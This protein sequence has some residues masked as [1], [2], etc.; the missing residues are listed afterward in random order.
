MK[1]PRLIIEDGGPKAPGYIVTF[2]DM[3]TLLLTF[4]VM[5]QTLASTQDAEIFNKGRDAFIK[6][7]RYIGLGVLFDRGNV[8]ALDHHKTKYYINNPEELT[9]KRTIDA[10][11]EEIRR[12]LERLRQSTTIVPSTIVGK[13]ANFSVANVHFSPGRD[14]LDGPAK[15]FLTGFSQDLLQNTV[16][17]PVALYVLGL[18]SDVKS[19]KEQWLLSAR[20]AGTVADFLRNALSSAGQGQT[21]RSL[22]SGKTKWSVYSWGA[23]PGGDWV[24][25]DSPISKHSQILIAVLRASD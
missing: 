7:I 11:A 25:W 1:R 16:R 15:T 12:I 2:S 4:F 5:L 13:K 23:G 19:E 18:A 21:Q 22:V 17:E 6:S 8:T 20:R 3:I 24:R 10:R 9:D 14:D